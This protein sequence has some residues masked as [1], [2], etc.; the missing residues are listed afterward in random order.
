M[1]LSTFMYVYIHT[2]VKYTFVNDAIVVSINICFYKKEREKTNVDICKYE[3]IYFEYIYIYVCMTSRK[4]LQ[5]LKA[6]FQEPR[7]ER[8][9]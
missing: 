2:E 6:G 4:L 5:D 8:R 1:Y 9:R 3:Y 7:T